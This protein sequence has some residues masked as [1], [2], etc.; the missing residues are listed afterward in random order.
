MSGSTDSVWRETAIRYC[1]FIVFGG[2]NHGEHDPLWTDVK[3]FL[4]PSCGGL[5][6]ADDGWGVGR[7]ES[8]EDLEGLMDSSRAVFHVDDCKVVTRECDDLGQSG[9]EGEEEDA[10]EGFAIAEAGLERG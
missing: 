2:V 3:G 9:G 4:R 7:G 8:A 1:L 5:R 6:E 10:I